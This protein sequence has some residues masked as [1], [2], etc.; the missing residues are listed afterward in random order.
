MDVA[1]VQLIFMYAWLGGAMYFIWRLGRLV[2]DFVEALASLTDTSTQLVREMT[3]QAR[4]A[5][6]HLAEAAAQNPLL[7][8]E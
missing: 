8:V 6:D 4:A 7:A 2:H 3:T 1:T 5:V